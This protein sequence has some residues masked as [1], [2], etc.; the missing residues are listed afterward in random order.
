MAFPVF[1]E[2]TM[3]YH[4]PDTNKMMSKDK[5]EAVLGIAQQQQQ[6][7]GGALVGGA[8]AVGA[9]GAIAQVPLLEQILTVQNDMLTAIKDVSNNLL[10]MLGFDEDEARRRKEGLTE[11]NKEIG[12]E[13]GAGSEGIDDAIDE[14]GGGGR[15]GKGWI[16]AL[17][18]GGLFLKLGKMFAPI[19]AFFGPKGM[20]FKLFGRFGPLGVLILGFTLFYK[21]AD[22]IGVALAPAIDKIKEIVVKLQPLIDLVMKIGDFLIKDFITTVGEA[23]EYLFGGIEKFIDGVKLC[24]R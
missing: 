9:D 17:L 12:G 16:G 13:G 5:A 24:L 20:L 18:G 14:A 7:V 11:K 4:D 10:D 19:L 3:R 2:G 1:N 22:E 23:F 21:Y 8:G 6:I 15:K